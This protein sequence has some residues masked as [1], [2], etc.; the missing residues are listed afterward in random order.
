M[1]F[2]IVSETTQRMILDK[3]EL[4]TCPVL[5]F[6]SC[7]I[8]YHPLAR[9]SHRSLQVLLTFPQVDDRVPFEVFPRVETSQD[10]HY[11]D[12]AWQDFR[13]LTLGFNIVLRMS[14]RCS[15]LTRSV[16][17][18]ITTLEN[19]TCSIVVVLCVVQ[20]FFRVFPRFL[21]KLFL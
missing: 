11:V 13:I 20:T 16:L 18:K 17:F 6:Y 12:L 1:T 7:R 9:T 15:L 4:I 3:P 5:A 2:S 8:S 10:L 21:L 19:P 14:C